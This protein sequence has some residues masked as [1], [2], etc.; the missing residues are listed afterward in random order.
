MAA[1]RDRAA[2]RSTL[3][4]AVILA[5]LGDQSAAVA[6]SGR[7]IALSQFSSY[8]HLICARVLSF[9]G[10]RVAA[11]RHVDFGLT[12]QSD[13]PGLIELHGALRQAGGD[14]KGAIADYDRAIASGALEGVHVRKASALMMLQDTNAAVREWSLALLRD[15]ELPEAFLGR[16]RSHIRLRHWDLALADLEQAASWAHADPKIE[17]AIAASYLICLGQRPDRLP[18]FLTITRRAAA[19]IW[20]SRDGRPRLAS[21]MD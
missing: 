4:R 9:G 11:A 14:P 19:H 18:R 20:Q 12:I 17:V 15:P 10:D 13:E 5:A 8:A 21:A 7:A 2:F 3:T 1:G 16:A 6:S